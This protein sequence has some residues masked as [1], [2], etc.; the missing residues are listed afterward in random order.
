MKRILI[1]IICIMITQQAIS[2]T[3][4]TFK[5]DNGFTVILAEDRSEPKIYGAVVAKAGSKNDPEGMTGMAHYFEHIMFKGT[6]RTGTVDYEKEKPYLDQ[7][8]ALYDELAP[9]SGNEAKR[10][11]ILKEINELSI[12]ANKYAIPGETDK[13]LKKYGGTEINAYTSYDHTVYHN[14]F[15]P[16]QLEKWLKIYA[17]RFRN[18]VFRMFQAELETIYEERNMYADQMGSKA[19]EDILKYVVKKHP[20]RNPILGTVKDL[21]TPS[22]NKMMQFYREYYVAGN[23][24]LILIG[25]FAADEILPYIKEAFGD[26]PTGAVP[27]FPTDK[28]REDP[29][30]IREFYSGRYIPVKAGITC[31]RSVP[32]GHPDKIALN[33]CNNILSNELQTGLLDRLRTDNKLMMSMAQQISC[34]D[35]GVIA[36]FFVPKLMGSLKKAEAEAMNAVAQLKSGNF[37]DEL[38]E[39]IRISFARY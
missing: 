19:I 28:Y 17:E 4:K 26:L 24:G 39:N 16:N 36:V 11:E 6:D 12:E 15:P 14:S 18:P 37:S 5:L 25:D 2:Q 7:I 8:A 29:F 10:N 34:N 21:K 22:I 38:L 20:Y 3:V 32:T 30:K 13:L 1:Y 31:Y 33:Y 27:E 9:V 23:M 35:M